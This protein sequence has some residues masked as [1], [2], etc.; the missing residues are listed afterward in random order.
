MRSLIGLVVIGAA[1]GVWA[2][3]WGGRTAWFALGVAVLLW[4]YGLLVYL[5]VRRGVRVERLFLGLEHTF[6]NLG[7]RETKP[8]EAGLLYVFTGESLSF[9]Y[10]VSLPARG[11]PGVWLRFEERW[12]HTGTGEAVTL[13][14]YAPAGFRGEARLT[15][16]LAGLGRGVYA[17]AERTVTAGDAF[18][19]LRV[20]RRSPA[21]GQL[22]V[23]PRLLPAAADPGAAF[24]EAR[25]GK[26]PPN[27]ASVPQVIGTRPYAPGDPLRRIHWRS[28][29]RTGEL[30]AK[31][32]ELPAIGRQLIGLDAAG[33]GSSTGD[34]LW[35]DPALTAAAE[36][37]AGLALRA[38]EQG[39][40]VRLAVSDGR[41]GSVEAQGRGRLRDVLA[42][43]AAVP[44]GDPRPQAFAELALREALAAGGG[45]VTLVT[46]RADAQL[47][48]VLRRLPGRAVQLVYVQGPWSGGSAAAV[49]SWLQQLEAI[50]CRV[51][52]V[53][54]PAVS[55]APQ[56]GGDGYAASGH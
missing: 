26:R 34:A 56:I 3:T 15:G 27:G 50:G 51:T 47:I 30:R 23:L 17:A 8:V 45:A 9:A 14:A 42:L 19:L 13:C 22:L 1:A 7:A 43:L 52:V 38:L 29:A 6:S 31:E 41:G 12:V 5:S 4:I 21:E 37:A 10:R 36:A 48:P 46:A 18:G 33:A 40:R 2:A 28:S 11:L 49:E 55:S 53:S 20:Q 24:E 35:A 16:R 39:L 54:A 32:L 44:Q 25:R